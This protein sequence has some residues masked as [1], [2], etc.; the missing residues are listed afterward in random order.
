MKTITKISIVIFCLIIFLTGCRN[1][2]TEEKLALNNTAD[3]KHDDT[4]SYYGN[5]SCYSPGE[6]FKTEEEFFEFVEGND[7]MKESLLEKAKTK[8]KNLK[9]NEIEL[10]LPGKAPDGF[11]ISNIKWDEIAIT[12]DYVCEAPYREELHDIII[13]NRVSDTSIDPNDDRLKVPVEGA[14]EIQSEIEELGLDGYM[15]KY[16]ILPDLYRDIINFSTTYSLNW[17][18]THEESNTLKEAIF[19]RELS[20]TNIPG[21]YGRL[22]RYPGV[23]N[24]LMY[25]VF[26]LENDY[27]FSICLPCEYTDP[28]STENFEITDVDSGKT[29]KI[30]KSIFDIKSKIIELD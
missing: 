19:M 26:W 27:L 16:G 9:E 13:D 1:N 23:L 22:I 20:E 10:M 30:P 14:D 2:N 18:Y 8:N 24:P 3:S 5:E 17:V 29:Y 4:S 15:E 12:Y 6:D 21:Y 28:N 25:E 11:E 7:Y